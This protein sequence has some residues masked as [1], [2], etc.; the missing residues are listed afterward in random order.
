MAGWS[1]G[2]NVFRCSGVRC[3][4]FF[5]VLMFLGISLRH[6]VFVIPCSIFNCVQVFM[7]SG[8]HVFYDVLAC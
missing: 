5:E 6:S 1:V 3:S 4:G 8:V 7:C 2:D